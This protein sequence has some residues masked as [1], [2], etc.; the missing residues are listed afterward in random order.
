MSTNIKVTNVPKLTTT[1]AYAWEKAITG[2][3]QRERVLRWVKGTKQKPILADQY[4]NEQ[5]KREAEE[6]IEAWEDTDALATGI[7][8]QSISNDFLHIVDVKIG[9]HY[10][11]LLL[12][13]VQ[14]I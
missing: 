11:M 8:V 14:H 13:G 1:N 12:I 2:Q 7:M 9:L 10:Y 5:T 6:A 4:A 3:F